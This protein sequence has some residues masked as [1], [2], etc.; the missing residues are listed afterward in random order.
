[1]AVAPVK[2]SRT[3]LSA[4]ESSRSPCTD[5]DVVVAIAGQLRGAGLIPVDEFVGLRAGELALLAE[6]GKP[7]PL[8]TV[9]G[10]VGVEVHLVQ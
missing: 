9:R 10:G 1:M 6:F 7:L 8:R 5:C 2:R 4:S 3:R